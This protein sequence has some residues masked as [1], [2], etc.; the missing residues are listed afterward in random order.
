VRSFDID[1]T[2]GFMPIQTADGALYFSFVKQVA[3]ECVIKI[4]FEHETNAL[5]QKV[6]M[7]R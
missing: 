4:V 6:S 3:P 2:T 1:V 5:A 7:A